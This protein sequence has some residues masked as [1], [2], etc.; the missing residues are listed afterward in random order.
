[1]E[2]FIVIDATHGTEEGKIMKDKDC[3]QCPKCQQVSDEVELR[4]EMQ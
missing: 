2:K 1:M 4:K 3:Y